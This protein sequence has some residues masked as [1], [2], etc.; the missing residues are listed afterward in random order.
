VTVEGRAFEPESNA[1][2]EGPR[3]RG[4]VGDSD[5]GGPLSLSLSVRSDTTAARATF[6][7]KL[8]VR[9]SEGPGGPERASPSQW[10]CRGLADR[11]TATRRAPTR[12]RSSE[13]AFLVRRSSRTVTVMVA[14]TV[15]LPA[16]QAHRTTRLGAFF[17]Q[18]E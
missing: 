8:T 7:V 6:R 17:P 18:S 13:S 5:R 1:G 15:V 9:D 3:A 12:T 2:G 10:H 14:S 16:G 11:R 4:A